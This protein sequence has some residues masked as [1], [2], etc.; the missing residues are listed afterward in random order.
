MP[1]IKSSV[2]GECDG[3]QTRNAPLAV[4][5]HA[6]GIAAFPLDRDV[7]ASILERVSATMDEIRVARITVIVFAVLWTSML[8]L[9]I[10]SGS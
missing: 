5:D 9:H 1:S 2:P 8:G 6:Q 3:Q 7:P 4:A 10:L